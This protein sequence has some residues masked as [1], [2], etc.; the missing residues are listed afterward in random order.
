MRKIK[1]FIQSICCSYIYPFVTY[2]IFGPVY[3]VL[4]L[5]KMYSQYAI[6]NNWWASGVYPWLMQPLK[7]IGTENIDPAKRYIIVANHAS[8][9][10]IP[11]IISLFKTPITWVVKE[12]LVKKPVVGQMILLGMGT[13]IVRSNA[14]AAQ[15]TMIERTSQ[16]RN[17][18]NPHIAVF[19]EGTR[20]TDGNIASFKRG[21][22]L[23]MRKYEMDI[24]PIT[25]NGFYTFAPR[26]RFTTDP[27]AKLEVIVHKPLVYDAL[28]NMDDKTISQMTQEIIIAKYHV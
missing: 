27:N 28:K 25:L 8:Y 13:P 20:T 15:D 12:S 3:M 14:R 2:F 5:F 22:V 24:L 7:V 21:F 18:M 9:L 19:P 6:L 4:L 1:I 10:D 17:K 11:A 23:L 16:L 26:N